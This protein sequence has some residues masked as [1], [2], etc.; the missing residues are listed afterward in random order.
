M[1]QILHIL[2]KDVRR[3]WPEILIS[4]AVLAL[5]T[6]RELQPWRNAFEVEAISRSPLFY[7]LSE[8]YFAPALIIFWIF[9]VI[10][11]VQGESLVGD[12]QWWTTKPYIWWQLLLA[13]L[14]FIFV[15]VCVPLFLVQLFLL[16]HFQYPILSNVPAL[17]M[18]Q[19]SLFTLLVVF[20]VLLASLTKNLGQLLLVVGVIVLIVG[21]TVWINRHNTT[22]AMEDTPPYI[23]YFLQVFGWGSIAVVSTWQ[24]ARRRR[25][26][27]ITALLLSLM[28]VIA[29]NGLFT[30][31]NVVE[32]RYTPVDSSQAPVRISAKPIESS[33][34][35]KDF[36]HDPSPDVRLKIP[37]AVSGVASGTFVELNGA[38]IYADSPESSA[39]SRGWLNE[40]SV[41]WPEDQ[42]KVLG[43]SVTR[44]GYEKFKNKPLHLHIDLALSEYHAADVRPL[45]IRTSSF[46]DES[47]GSCRISQFLRAEVRCLYAIRNP[48]FVLRF[49]PDKSGCID[50]ADDRLVQADTVSYAWQSYGEPGFPNP[51]LNPISDYSIWFQPVS[52]TSTAKADSS[53]VRQVRLCPGTE[54]TVSRPVLTRQLRIQFDLPNTRLEDLAEPPLHFTFR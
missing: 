19:F 48:S 40:R 38:R 44:K 37:V 26:L 3:H 41:F 54:L 27:S 29:V 43:Y 5:Y 50:Y 17:A 23:G 34:E 52:L 7:I 49:D 28:F 24:F 21:V 8:R 30:S 18:M 11:V 33:H 10:R 15:F 12:R 4:L 20:V 13:K 36:S 14:L 42:E 53:K 1:D 45:L 47:L 35:L 51:E 32:R 22:S 25:W 39:W 31:S 6:H 2:K 9:L 16:H 46:S